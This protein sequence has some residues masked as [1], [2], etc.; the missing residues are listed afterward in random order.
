MPPLPLLLPVPVP[1]PVPDP[2]PLPLREPVP[3]LPVEPVPDG[4]QSTLDC[5]KEPLSPERFDVLLPVL[6]PVPLELP[7]DPLFPDCATLPSG[8]SALDPRAL[9]PELLLEE[10]P[11]LPGDFDEPVPV[12]PLPCE[13]LPLDEPPLV[14]DQPGCMQNASVLERANAEKTIRFLF[15]RYLPPFLDY[16]RLALAV[17]PLVACNTQS[18]FHSKQTSFSREKR[19]LLLLGWFERRSIALGISVGVRIPRQSSPQNARS[20][21][22]P[23]PRVGTES[24]MARR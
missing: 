22:I 3:L 19:S 8:Q 18:M 6:E 21:R 9:L 14:C 20:S 16:A 23:S 10:P 11:E 7:D 12:A 24:R 2:D 4:G 5:A 17:R 1:D 13:L 15:I